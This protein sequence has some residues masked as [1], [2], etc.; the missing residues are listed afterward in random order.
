MLTKTE[1]IVLRCYRYKDNHFLA[2]ILTRESGIVTY[3]VYAP[4]S[5][6]SRTK[7]SY[8]Q[9][10]TLLEIDA[11]HKSN[12]TIQTI[13]ELHPLSISVNIIS[14]PYKTAIALFV[15]EVIN[16]C[17]PPENPDAELYHTI[18]NVIKSIDS[19]TPVDSH[20]ALKFLLTLS[21]YLGFNP[22]HDEERLVINEF[23][24]SSDISSEERILF[25]RF[26]EAYNNGNVNV[27]RHEERQNIL[28]TMLRYFKF[29]LPDMPQ[30]HSS[31]V[32]AAV[33]EG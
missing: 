18:R 14:N 5:K 6:R 33:F 15:A 10:L 7:M 25:T 4:E 12:R 21:D 32:L 1:G 30:I 23:L 28:R 22:T 2:H 17:V 20:F 9:P 11:D 8:F 13:K 19:D 26:I 16:A 27:F 31:E 24:G 29:N 3:A